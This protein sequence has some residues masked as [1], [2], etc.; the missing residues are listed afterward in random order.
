MTKDKKDDELSTM[1][2][3]NKFAEFFLNIPPD[4][5]GDLTELKEMHK[6]ETT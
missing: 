5:L 3:I 6:D 2:D 1:E 4:A